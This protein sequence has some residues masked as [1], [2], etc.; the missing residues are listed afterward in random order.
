MSVASIVALSGGVGGA[1]LVKG[2]SLCD[3]DLS[4]IVNTADDFEHWGLHISPDL[5]SVMYALADLSDPVR[6][7]GVRG[8]T[9]HTLEAMGGYGGDKWFQLGDR[10]LATHLI[11]T[12]ELNQ[13]HTLTEVTTDLC[14]RL[15][16]RTAVLPMS[17]DPVL[18]QVN[19]PDGWLDFQVY[20]VRERCKPKVCEI[21]FEGIASAAPSE[22]VLEA[23][24][25][26]KLIV[27]CP[28]NPL[29]S[30]DPILSL[31]G[32]R[33]ALKKTA[34]PVVAVS[35]I[36]AG[37]AI[38]GPTVEM[39]S[40]LNI[41]TTPMGVARHYGDVLEGFV[42]DA[43]DAGMRPDI[44]S[45]GLKVQVADTLMQSDDD[46]EMLAQSVLDAWLP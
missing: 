36:I 46:K 5:D 27:I 3:V 30:V 7:W 16:I 24:A 11:R 40:G 25:A 21:R 45:L 29:V 9:W 19:T 14:R 15:N 28:S 13:G 37:R 22:A 1:K 6:G 38:K 32:L 26:A 39:L 42:L 20:F 34:A 41:E 17:D 8:E 2:L 4:A 12:Q 18:T 23:I 44:E 33:A 10:D 35:P 31:P 43:Q